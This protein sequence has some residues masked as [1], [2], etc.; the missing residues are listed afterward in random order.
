MVQWFLALPSI[1]K[2]GLLVIAL[3]VV[4]AVV[5]GLTRN[6]SDMM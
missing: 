3:L 5:A 4:V 6:R 1:D 2:I